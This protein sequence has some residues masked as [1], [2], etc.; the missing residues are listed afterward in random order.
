[1]KIDSV[2]PKIF[3]SKNHSAVA[4]KKYVRPS[5]YIRVGFLLPV[6][7]NIIALINEAVIV[8]HHHLFAQVVSGLVKIF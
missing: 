4:S 3:H 7:E 1:M 2:M 5:S 6:E 8:A